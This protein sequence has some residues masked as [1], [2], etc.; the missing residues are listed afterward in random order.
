MMRVPRILGVLQK[1]LRTK[2]FEET[3]L[4]HTSMLRLEKRYSEKHE[5]AELNQDKS[6][7]VGISQYAADALGDVVFASLPD[8][9]QDVNTQTECGALESVK[10]AS[11][12]YSPLA[13][14]V[15]E[16]NESVEDK[17]SLI[18]TSPEEKGWLFRLS[19]ADS[20]DFKN[21]MNKD[22]YTKFLESQTEDLD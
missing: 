12:I 11:E 1:T 13:G 17:P 3:R 10:A 15:L 7:S 4:I 16:K 22:E 6:V 14:T 20:S 18:N 19:V 2:Y 5:W 8:P 21:L 9:G